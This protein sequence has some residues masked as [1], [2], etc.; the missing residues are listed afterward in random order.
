MRARRGECRRRGFTCGNLVLQRVVLSAA[1]ASR[2]CWAKHHP[3]WQL[4]GAGPRGWTVTSA[5]GSLVIMQDTLMP[6]DVLAYDGNYAAWLGGVLN[7]VNAIE[8]PIILP[9]NGATL[10]FRWRLQ[11]TE[12]QC[13]NDVL[14]VSLNGVLIDKLALCQPRTTSDYVAYSRNLQSWA[15]QRVVLQLRVQTNGSLSSNLFVDDVRVE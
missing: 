9:M 13:H 1:G 4:R 3:Q 11:S 6:P 12:T 5:K 7:E 15:G 2:P 14:L 8:Q 10:A